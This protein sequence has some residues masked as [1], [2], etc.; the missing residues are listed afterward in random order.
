MAGGQVKRN[1]AQ[2]FGVDGSLQPLPIIGR[3]TGEAVD[4]FHQQYVTFARVLQQA[5]Q[6]GPVGLGAA[7]VLQVLGGNRLSVLV[8]ELLQGRAG[9][10]GVLLDGGGAKVGANEHD[11]SPVSLWVLH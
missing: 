11:L 9:A 2:T 7:G 10:A 6:L 1:D 8:G 5:Q 3:Q 4:G